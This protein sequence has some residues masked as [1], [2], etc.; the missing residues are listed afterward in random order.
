MDGACL[1]SVRT[2][3]LVSFSGWLPQLNAAIVI[4]ADQPHASENHAVL[5]LSGG[6][7]SGSR[8]VVC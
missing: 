7:S 3:D 8:Y 1:N 6:G 5:G 2:H 4:V